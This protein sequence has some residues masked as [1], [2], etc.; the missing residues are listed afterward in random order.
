M[1][2]NTEQFVAL[3]QKLAAGE[4][5]FEQAQQ[6]EAELNPDAR[7]AS[8]YMTIHDLYERHRITVQEAR[9]R[10]ERIGRL[11]DFECDFENIP[12]EHKRSSRLYK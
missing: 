3:L 1:N 10:C 11:R 8:D 5:T 2:G 4:I 6:A 7:L 12:I 9:R